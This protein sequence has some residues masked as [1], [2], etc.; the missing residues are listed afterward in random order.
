MT[1][2]KDEEKVKEEGRLI[3]EKLSNHIK[4]SVS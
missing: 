2:I 3:L 1:N 4:G